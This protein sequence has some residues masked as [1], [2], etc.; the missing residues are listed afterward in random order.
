MEQGLCNRCVSLSRSQPQHVPGEDPRRPQPQIQGAGQ[1]L[2][3][4]NTAR[5]RGGSRP[6]PEPREAPASSLRGGSGQRAWLPCPPPRLVGALFLTGVGR[7]PVCGSVWTL[8]QGSSRVPGHGLTAPPDVPEGSA[9]LGKSA[10]HGAECCA[11][12]TVL[13]LVLGLDGRRSCS[14]RPDSDATSH[15]AF[16]PPPPSYPQCNVFMVWVFLVSLS[17][18]SQRGFLAVTAPPL[19]GDLV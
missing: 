18:V 2:P 5:F 17:V 14:L 8:A 16:F 19:K 3:E 15:Q 12:P 7:P 6:Y 11:A 9:H 10:P 4:D 13:S 1:L